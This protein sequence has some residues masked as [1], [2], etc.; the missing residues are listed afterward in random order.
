VIPRTAAANVDLMLG[1]GAEGAIVQ[2]DDVE[3][4]RAFAAAHL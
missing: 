3:A 4:M 1:A 2:F